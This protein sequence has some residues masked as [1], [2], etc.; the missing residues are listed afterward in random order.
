MHKAAQSCLTCSG[1]GEIASEQGPEPC[2]DCFGAGQ[3]LDPSTKIEWRLRRMERSCHEWG[4]DGESAAR[5]LIHELR[6]NREALL[7]ILTRCQDAEA[8]DTL[9]TDVKYFANEALGLYE[10]Q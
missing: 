4:R 8:V 6:T 3:N 2:P 10:K 5:W 1:S 7:R 9:A